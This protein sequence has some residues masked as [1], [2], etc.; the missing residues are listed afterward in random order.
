MPLFFGA[1]YAL[2]N[3]G[4]FLMANNIACGNQNLPSIEDAVPG[5]VISI[6]GLL[7]GIIVKTRELSLKTQRNK[8]NLEK[9]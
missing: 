4:T 5:F 2:E 8:K 7:I 6:I 9:T 3:F 1:M